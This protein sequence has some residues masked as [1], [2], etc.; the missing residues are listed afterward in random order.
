MNNIWITCKK[1]LRSIFRD[2]KTFLTLFIFPF[3]IPAFI[4]LYS[5]IYDKEMDNDVYEIGIDYEINQIETNLL[6]EYNLKP[7][8]YKNISDMEMAYQDKDIYA[9]IDYDKEHDEYII[10]VNDESED[11]MYVSN[12]LNSYFESYNKYLGN[13]SLIGED[14]DVDSI[15]DKVHY[16][17]IELEGE[18]F[19]LNLMFSLAFT[20]IIMAIVMATTNMATTATAVEKE[21]GTLE[22]ILTFPIKVKDLILGKYIASVIMGFFASLL[23]FILT[24]VSLFIAVSRYRV[25]EGISFRFDVI[26]I[27]I[28]IIMIMLASLFIAGLSF[29]V[30][31]RTR[32]YKE[33]QSVSSALNMVCI[34]PMFISMFHISISRF[35]YLIPIFNYTQVLMDI[36]SGEADVLSI[37]MVFLSSF[38]YVIFVI[39]YIIKRYKTEKV[40]FG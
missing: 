14:I 35:Y 16:K 6:D 29:A 13:L 7:I 38:V 30:T 22:T 24:V 28:S 1:E 20:Y 27:I 11:G 36:F 12:Y 15:Y 23:G 37:L 17:T 39:Y 5:E 26:G 32:S 33:A 2:K 3:L 8:V 19:M 10:Y 31:S 21:N 25:F 34:I 18:N 4:F 9:Y 40:L